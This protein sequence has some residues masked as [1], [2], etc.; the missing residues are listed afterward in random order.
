MK[1]NRVAWLKQKVENSKF[2]YDD[3][4]EE[5]GINRTTVYRWLNDEKLSD[6]RLKKIADVI[7]I[8][9]TV[10]FEGMDYLYTEKGINYKERWESSQQE[11]NV[12]RDRL[13]KY[14]VKNEN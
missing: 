11:V 10:E 1:T 3:I 2:T 12:L 6:A 9:L 13:A 4:A 7:G 14:E 8:D 5:I